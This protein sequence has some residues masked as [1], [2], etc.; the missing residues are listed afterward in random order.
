LRRLAGLW[1][2]RSFGL[3]VRQVDADPVAAARSA[4][5]AAYNPEVGSLLARPGVV[6]HLHAAAVAVMVWT[7]DD[8]AQWAA[9]TDLG[10][11][12]IITNTPGELLA[13][14]SARGG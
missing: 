13:Y 10:V 4:G 9:L 11:D 6:A 7:S 2:G 1:T 3:L 12:A 8:P 14:Q 5:A